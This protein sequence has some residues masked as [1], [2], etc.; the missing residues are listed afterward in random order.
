MYLICVATYETEF[1]EAIVCQIDVDVRD[2]VKEAE[3]RRPRSLRWH[4]SSAL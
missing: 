1:C 2:V 4:A 3:R